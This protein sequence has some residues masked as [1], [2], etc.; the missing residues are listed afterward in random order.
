MWGRLTG[1]LDRPFFVER[2]AKSRVRARDDVKD[3]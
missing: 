2:E 1:L 3:V